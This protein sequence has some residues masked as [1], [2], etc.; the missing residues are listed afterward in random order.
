MYILLLSVIDDN[1]SF[2]LEVE[3]ELMT[4]L[5]IEITK[6]TR[7]PMVDLAN[8]KRLDRFPLT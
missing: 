8:R 3:I 4:G 6:A 2:G 1:S 7:I 5:T